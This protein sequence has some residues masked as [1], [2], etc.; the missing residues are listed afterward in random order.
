MAGQW[1]YDTRWGAMQGHQPAPGEVVGWFVAAGNL[2]DSGNVIAK[3][4][5]RVLF[6]PYGQNYTSGASA[7]SLK[8]K[9]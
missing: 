5:S 4:R 8:L 9:R 6:L 1:F 7:S 2:R 3:E